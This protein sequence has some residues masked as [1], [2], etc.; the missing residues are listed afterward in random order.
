MA[1]QLIVEFLHALAEIRFHLAAQVFERAVDVRVRCLDGTFEFAAKLLPL[2][3]L[4]S[5]KMCAGVL[6]E[7]EVG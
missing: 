3:P 5:H 4:L 7:A 1:K 6:L 2:L